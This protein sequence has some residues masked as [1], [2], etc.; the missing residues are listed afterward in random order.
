MS[1]GVPSLLDAAVVHH[2]DA[3][4][5]DH[6]LGLVVRDVDRGV[7]ELVVQAADLEAHLLAQVGVEVGQRLVEQQ[8]LRLDH[9]RARQRHALLLAAGQLAGIALGQ[10]LELRRRRGSRRRCG[11]IVACVQ[12]AQLRP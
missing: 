8:H 2:H 7:A 9:Q 12:L 3:V 4:G 6:R 1:S 5:G 10:R 11:A